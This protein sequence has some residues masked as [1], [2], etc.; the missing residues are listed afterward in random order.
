MSL[1]VKSG[2]KKLPDIGEEELV[3]KQSRDDFASARRK[4]RSAKKLS[5]IAF[6][7]SSIFLSILAL[8]GVVLLFVMV[9]IP[10]M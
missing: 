9:I 8:A 5:S 2:I 6:T 3:T 1:A 7:V 10:N 4:I